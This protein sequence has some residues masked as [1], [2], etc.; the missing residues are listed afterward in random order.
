MMRF[1]R[2]GFVRLTVV[3]GRCNFSSVVPTT[4]SSSLVTKT[5]DKLKKTFLPHTGP[6]EPIV[7]FDALSCDEYW[8]DDWMCTSDS[9]Y[10]GPSHAKLTYEIDSPVSGKG[11][12]E[13]EDTAVKDTEVMDKYGNNPF[14]GFPFLRFEGSVD[15]SVRKSK[16]LGVSGGFC[17]FR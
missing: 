12:D 8:E 9:S 7:V 15:M 14:S 6:L 10:G 17:A 11:G 3:S 2:K 1:A 4:S 16:E 13:C 5:F